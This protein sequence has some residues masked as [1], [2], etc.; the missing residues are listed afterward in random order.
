MRQPGPTYVDYPADPVWPLPAMC[1]GLEMHAFAVTP[2]RPERLQALTDERL[3]APMGQPGLF[4][5]LPLV[6]LTF[7]HY[8]RAYA[9][10]SPGYD[11]R[12]S[13]RYG[14]V[15]SW[16][17]V[18]ATRDYGAHVRRGNLAVLVPYLYVDSFYAAAGGREL[19]GLPKKL[20]AI[21]MPLAAGE[22][23]IYTLDAVAFRRFAPDA[24]A[25]TERLL[26]ITRVGEGRL[27]Q[28][29][30]DLSRTG[31]QLLERVLRVPGAV[32]DRVTRAPG[33]VT[34]RGEWSS[35]EAALGGMLRQALDLP[36]VG[37]LAK[38]LQPMLLLDD[39]LE[40]TT[41]ALLK[42]MGGGIPAIALKQLRSS[43]F[44]TEAC[45]QSV[46]LFTAPVPRLTG[47]L[48]G[49]NYRLRF[50]PCESDPMADDLGLPE[51]FETR[52]AFR[53]NLDME[54]VQ[55]TRLWP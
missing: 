15:A 18:Y 6:L 21:R 32:V 7:G 24:I 28:S 39:A 46:Q 41:E 19:L 23:A 30:H 31:A 47:G 40:L 55:T 38:V 48:L 27:A 10:N 13:I 16:V 1:K 45:Y 54:L 42:L 34:D 14:E 12:G 5:A 50:H 53:V 49:G 9:T 17:F 35:W 26:E 36:I 37:E 29:W 2:A 52:A 51:V 44:P 8:D 11:R 3:N 22:R 33:H 20:G 43:E 4:R 25:R